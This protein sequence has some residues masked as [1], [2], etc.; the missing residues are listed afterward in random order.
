MGMRLAPLP[1]PQ[2]VI[3]EHLSPLATNYPTH[4]CCW[5]E[6]ATLAKKKEKKRKNKMAAPVHPQSLEMT[7][8][9]ND[10]C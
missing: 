2:A 3:C 9:R 5:L 6:S 7:H 4:L 1:S 8:V 10:P